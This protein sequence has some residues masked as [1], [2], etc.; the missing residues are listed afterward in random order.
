MENTPS[1]IPSDEVLKPFKKINLPVFPPMTNPVTDTP[2]Y[3]KLVRNDQGEINK[4]KDI[5]QRLNDFRELIEKQQYV[6]LGSKSKQDGGGT[7]KDTQRVLSILEHEIKGLLLKVNRI[8]LDNIIS[9]SG[10]DAAEESDNDKIKKY[11]QRLWSNVE[12]TST[13][14]PIQSGGNPW[15]K[16]DNNQTNQDGYYLFDQHSSYQNFGTED[17]PSHN[18]NITLPDSKNKIKTYLGRCVDLQILY[19]RKHLE[20][21]KAHT[22]NHKVYDFF[23]NINKYLFNILYHIKKETPKKETVKIAKPYLQ[24]LKDNYLDPQ[25]S[26]DDLLTAMNE[27]E[28]NLPSDQSSE[29]KDTGSTGST[30]VPRVAEVAKPTGVSRTDQVSRAEVAKPTRFSRV[31][32]VRKLAS[33]RDRA[34]AARVPR[35]PEVTKS[36]W[37]P[38]IKNMYKNKK[39]GAYDTVM[40]HNFEIFNRLKSIAIKSEDITELNVTLDRYLELITRISPSSNL[41]LIY[42][43]S[44]ANID[45]LTAELSSNQ[46][47]NMN[48]T[49][50]TEENDTAFYFKITEEAKQATTKITD[51]NTL[52]KALYRCADLERLYILKHREL[53]IVFKS[54]IRGLKYCDIVY[55]NLLTTL[56]LFVDLSSLGALE[57]KV[58][59]P[60]KDVNKM[61]QD[62]K[63]MKT[64]FTQMLENTNFTDE[65]SKV[66]INEIILPIPDDMVKLR[67]RLKSALQSKISLTL[68][69]AVVEIKEMAGKYV[70]VIN[71]NRS[72]TPQTGVGENQT[73]RDLRQIKQII[74]TLPVDFDSFKKGAIQHIDLKIR[75]INYSN[76]KIE[77]INRG[78]RGNRGNQKGGE[79]R[80]RSQL[81]RRLRG[82][83]RIKKR[84]FARRRKFS[85]TNRN[86]SRTKR[87]RKQRRR[88]QHGKGRQRKLSIR[89]SKK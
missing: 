81:K 65:L 22:L 17:D 79:S 5:Y 45:A 13:R 64:R 70:I 75:Q 78:N 76:A 35:D 14:G 63:G 18:L 71:L 48:V 61:L 31:A 11:I 16:I 84:R 74:G 6:H 3:A 88:K 19:V 37:K 87:I 24:K 12:P 66:N 1:T 73:I 80:K 41:D 20:L 28:L 49:G 34:K 40:A 25:K 82:G 30:R 4:S 55:S 36:P 50:I 8:I 29:A 85:K 27:L 52:Q 68:Q 7:H 2:K 72:Q 58:F 53:L 60:I 46:W 86:V 32:Q 26:M 21:I 47:P 89:I 23:N 33:E 57:V 59:T 9:S 44:I 56:E 67:D 38:P 62:Q 42:N 83:R 77:S 43:S 51:I 54:I 10:E 15:K 39:G 69:N